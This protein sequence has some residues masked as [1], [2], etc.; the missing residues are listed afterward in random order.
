MQVVPNAEAKMFVFLGFVALLGVVFL[1]HVATEMN[2]RR[3]AVERGNMF[4]VAETLEV[5]WERGWL[6]IIKSRKAIKAFGLGDTAAMQ[7]LAKTSSMR[8]HVFVVDAY[9]CVTSWAVTWMMHII[10]AF[11]FLFM[12]IFVE[13]DQLDIGMVLP[14]YISLNTVRGG[15][16]PTRL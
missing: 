4:D 7:F 15:S 3:K 16:A 14:L 13:N 8:D 9:L 10:V 12:P 11:Y 5:K 6:D 2:E 1:V